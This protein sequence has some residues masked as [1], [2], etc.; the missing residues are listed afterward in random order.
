MTAGCLCLSIWT[1]AG[2]S[3]TA[4]P[5]PADEPHRIVCSRTVAP[6]PHKSRRILHHLAPTPKARQIESELW[7]LRFGSPGEQQL[8]VLPLHVTGTPP[9]FEYHPFRY[10][11]FKEQA[12]IRKKPA[13]RTAERIPTCGAEFY[14]DFAFMR[15][16][17]EDYRR[18]N[19]GTDRVI[20]SYDGNS[21]H[22]VIVDGASRRVWVFLTKTKDPPIEILRAFMTRFASH[23]GLV[24]TDQGGELARSGAVRTMMLT[25]FR[26]VVEPTG[27]NSPSQNGGAEIYNNTLAVKV[28]TLLYGAGLPAKFWSAALVHAVYLH[29]QLV[30]SAIN[31]TPY[32]AWC[33]RKPDVSNLCMFG[34]RVCIKRTGTR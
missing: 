14:M 27:A 12:Y 33:G 11:D 6:T 22:L 26:Y 24:R 15:S 18:P 16:S 20:T 17:T 10:I 34:A 32:E 9:A 30:Y 3:T 1:T 29:N 21:S 28:R 25:E 23:T 13:Q 19:K 7:L 5:M 2:A 31:K 4:L 8:D